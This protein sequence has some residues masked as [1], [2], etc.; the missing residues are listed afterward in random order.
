MYS[1]NQT[2]LQQTKEKN[3]SMEQELSTTQQ[4]IVDQYQQRIDAIQSQLAMQKRLTGNFVVYALTLAMV[5]LAVGVIFF[6][7]E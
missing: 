5:L 4:S 3:V 7:A 1:Q 6:Q 2:K